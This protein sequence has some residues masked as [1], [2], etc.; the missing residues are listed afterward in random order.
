MDIRE[1]WQRWCLSAPS[2]ETVQMSEDAVKRADAILHDAFLTLSSLRL[3][4][5]ELTA[6]GYTIQPA[7]LRLGKYQVALRVGH[8]IAYEVTDEATV[9]QIDVD[10]IS[11]SAGSL[12][13]RGK[14]PVELNVQVDGLDIQAHVSEMPFATKWVG[15]WRAVAP[16]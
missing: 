3:V 15:R 6:V 10:T 8:A 16:R 12:T 1:A 13:I 11:Y 7:G 4:N 14:M 5:N 9:D 2:L